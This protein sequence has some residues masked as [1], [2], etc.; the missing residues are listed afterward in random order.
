MFLSTIFLFKVIIYFQ[1]N[2]EFL[3]FQMI[4]L[5]EIVFLSSFQPTANNRKN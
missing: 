2:Q 4:V 1:L 3:K 5:L